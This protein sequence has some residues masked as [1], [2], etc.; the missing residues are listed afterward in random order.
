MTMHLQDQQSQ[1]LR[2]QMLFKLLR[3]ATTTKLAIPA[4][5]LERAVVTTQVGWVQLWV[6]VLV[7]I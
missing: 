2:Q 3:F 6:D 1:R 5:E 4:M 7:A